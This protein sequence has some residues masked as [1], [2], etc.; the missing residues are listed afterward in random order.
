[1]GIAVLK[2]EPRTRERGPTTRVEPFSVHRISAS[3][4]DPSAEHRLPDAEPIG[5]QVCACAFAAAAGLEF[6]QGAE[7]D[8]AHFLQPSPSKQ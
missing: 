3:E 2:L 5:A 4:V 6:V 8:R 1:M 7:E